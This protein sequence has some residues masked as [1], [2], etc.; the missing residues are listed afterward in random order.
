MCLLP[1]APLLLPSRSGKVTCCPSLPLLSLFLLL[2]R[3]GSGLHGV[4][5][6]REGQGM[7]VGLG[8]L[9]APCTTHG[10]GRGGEGRGGEARC[11]KGARLGA[12]RRGEGS[13]VRRGRRRWA[14]HQPTRTLDLTLCQ[15]LAAAGE[16]T[17]GWAAA[18]S[19][20]VYVRPCRPSFTGGS[21]CGSGPACRQAGRHARPPPWTD[22]PGRPPPWTDRPGRHPPW[23]DRPGRHP[24]PRGARVANPI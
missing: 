9:W 5:R 16:S 11:C 17:K 23:T 14:T 8:G 18:A 21:R 1:R 4:G 13:C 3:C 7:Y 24:P 12:R 10:E 22:R 2:V 15:Y 19:S 6:S 20:H